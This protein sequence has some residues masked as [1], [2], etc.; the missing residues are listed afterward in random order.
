MKPFVCL[1][2]TLLGIGADA[3]AAPAATVE[4]L[5]M[6]AWVERAGAREPLLAGMELQSGDRLRTGGNA[7]VV[8]RLEEGSQV[9]L[10]ADAEMD[11][12]LLAPPTEASGVFKGVLKVL[13]GA[14]RFTT[15]ALGKQRRRDIRASVSTVTIGI[16]GTDVWGKAEPSRDF[17]VLIEGKIDVEREG[18]TAQ[19]ME[20]PM[21]LFVAPKAS[22]ARPVQAANPDEVARWAAETELQE[23]EG[24]ARAD[25][26]WSVHL[27]SLRH[28]ESAQKLMRAVQAAG[29]AVQMQPVEVHGAMLSRVSIHGLASR[30][31]ALALRD[32]LSQELQLPQAWVESLR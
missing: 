25:G 17:V 5:Q 12:A 23:G 11:V 3:V 14:F 19:R 24:V 7:R 31:D 16:R 28:M 1:V 10:G 9:K 18:E 30:A 21:T 13:Q 4:G 26:R 15:S 8:L 27:A 32:R 2:V 22:A 6:P 29:Y 20:T